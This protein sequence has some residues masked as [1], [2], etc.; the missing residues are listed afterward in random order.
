MNTNNE[1]NTY[2][3]YTHYNMDMDTVNDE[4][5]LFIIPK[6]GVDDPN[7]TPHVYINEEYTTLGYNDF[8]EYCVIELNEC[9]QRRIEEAWTYLIPIVYKFPSTQQYIKIIHDSCSMHP[10][11]V[12]FSEKQFSSDITDN[13]KLISNSNNIIITSISEL[14]NE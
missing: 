3:L 8:A 1:V 9:G 14:Y 10:I 12:L 6:F 4:K 13:N 11:S 7:E 5:T 2:S